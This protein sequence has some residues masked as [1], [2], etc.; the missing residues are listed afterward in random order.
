MFHLLTYRP[1]L[2]RLICINLVALFLFSCE[3]EE[4]EPLKQDKPEPPPNEDY[5]T[6]GKKW[7][8]DQAYG[9]F[10]LNIPGPETPGGLVTYSFGE[11]GVSLVTQF[12]EGVI[13]VSYEE[14]VPCAQEEIK[15][16]LKTWSKV[17]QIDFEEKSFSDSTDIVFFIAPIKH[18][19]YGYPPGQ[20]GYEGKD[21][22][23]HV[24]FRP[25]MNYSC[26]KFYLFALH[27]VG[28]AIGLGHVETRNVMI[29]GVPDDDMPG[30]FPGD[31]KGAQSIYGWRKSWF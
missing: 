13:S 20:K 9:P 22:S 24:I 18:I 16:A 26:H 17:C 10:G 7:G 27:E 5:F 1:V 29:G 12:E 3:S 31:I 19:G 11:A 28:H 4:P 14:M 23:G 2:P 8:A 6:L 15:N 25:S 21:V 30:L